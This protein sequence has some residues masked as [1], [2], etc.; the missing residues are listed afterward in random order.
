MEP[1]KLKREEPFPT[2]QFSDCCP[3]VYLE[4]GKELADLPKEGSVTFQYVRTELTVTDSRTGKKTVRVVL[5][6]KEIEEYSE[7][8][9]T[10]DSE[11]EDVE[12]SDDSADVIDKHFKESDDEIED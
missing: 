8:T 5:S 7:K 1:I 2:T 6:L 10:E 4:G 3:S 11:D 12:E 9:D